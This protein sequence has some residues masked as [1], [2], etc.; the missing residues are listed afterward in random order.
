[1]IAIAPLTAILLTTLA[2]GILFV[3]LSSTVISRF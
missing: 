3:Y 2:G 1:V